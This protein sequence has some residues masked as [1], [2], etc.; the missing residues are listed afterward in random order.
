MN[1]ADRS[2]AMLD[3]ALRRRFSFNDMYPCKEA[4]E[5]LRKEKGIHDSEEDNALAKSI[6]TLKDINKEIID[7]SKLG[8][9]KMIGSSYFYQVE[10]KDDFEAVKRVWHHEIFPL[11]EEYCW[12]DRRL[13]KDVTDVSDFDIYDSTKRKLYRNEESLKS[14]LNIEDQSPADS[15]SEE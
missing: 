15:E 10:K 11:L 14:W 8:R 6:E 7:K 5:K 13:L 4:Y 1:T 9:D 12:D 2:I 3:I